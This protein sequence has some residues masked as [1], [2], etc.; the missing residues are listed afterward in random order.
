MVILLVDDEEDIHLTIGRFLADLG[1]EVVAA[2]DGG[3]ALKFLEKA[4]EVDLV[5]SDIRMP[6]INGIELLQA[7]RVRYPGTQVVLMTGHGDESTAT[8]ALRHGASDYLKKPVS[9]ETLLAYVERIE[10]RKKLE[11]EFAADSHRAR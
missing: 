3:E 5:L 9:L 11:A 8:A 4:D 6:G 7:V 10:E 1:H 2:A